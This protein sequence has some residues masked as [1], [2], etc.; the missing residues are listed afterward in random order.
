MLKK[1]IL[2]LIIVISSFYLI[3]CANLEDIIPNETEYGNW[4]GNYFY[5][6]NYK[7]KTIWSKR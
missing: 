3:S 5:F 4:D 7:C 6:E 2:G 1:I